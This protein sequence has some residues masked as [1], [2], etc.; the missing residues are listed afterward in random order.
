MNNIEINKYTRIGTINNF[1]S[2]NIGFGF[3]VIKNNIVHYCSFDY[4]PLYYQL[5]SCIV[6]TKSEKKNMLD[7]ER[8]KP[9]N[10]KYKLENFKCTK[11]DFNSSTE[12]E[13]DEWGF[14]VDLDFD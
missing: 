9:I 8:T 7:L 3:D 6:F 4:F 2:N 12:N 14:F 13:E 10:C 5:L 11:F 1:I